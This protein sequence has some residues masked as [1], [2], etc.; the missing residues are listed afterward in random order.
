MRAAVLVLMVILASCVRESDSD[1]ADAGPSKTYVGE[2]ERLG[3]DGQDFLVL[4]VGLDG[5]EEL[6]LQQKKL[7]YYLY[8]AAIAGHHIF[9]DQNTSL[10]SG[11]LRIYLRK[12]F[13][14]RKD[15]LRQRSKRCTTTSNTSGSIMANMELGPIPS[16]PPNYLT[17][18]MLQ[19]AARHAAD[20]GA[21][22]ALLP[23]E[24]LQAKLER[25]EP[26]IFDIDFE[27]L[28][29]NQKEGDDILST[30]FVNLYHP[31]VHFTGF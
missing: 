18:S 15:S 8:R 29:T 20:R 11:K 4:G 22:L 5:F 23:G 21:D 2:L 24:S 6:T 26:H 31:E 19:E 25:L 12:S 30:S 14:T 1:P 16:M 28:Q 13:Y 27:P 17:F 3:K 9:T 7:A 10:C